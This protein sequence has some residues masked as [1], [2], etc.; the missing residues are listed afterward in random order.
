VADELPLLKLVNVR[1]R[2]TRSVLLPRDWER[3]DALEGYVLT[4]G[5]RDIL[6]RLASSLRGE[7]PTRAWSL[8]GPYGSG[9]SAFALLVSQVLS[10]TGKA[11]ERARSAVKAVDGALWKRLTEGKKSLTHGGLLFPI[12][13]TGSREPLKSALV[14]GLRQGLRRCPGRTPRA[15]TKKLEDFAGRSLFGGTTADLVDLFEDV[16]KHVTRP[17]SGYQGLLLVIDELGKFLEYA[18]SHPEDGDVFALQTLA[19]AAARSEKPFLLLTILH[20]AIDRYTAHVSPARRQEWAKIQGRFEDVAFEEPTEQFLRL[21]A[22]AIE[23]GGSEPVRKSLEQYGRSLASEAW[24]QGCRSGSID[25]REFISLLTACMPLH[26]TAALVLGPLFRRLAQNERSLFAFLASGEPF[27]FQDF[28]RQQ[29]WGRSAGELY[30]LDQLYDYVTT[31]LGS[32]LYSQ[33]RGKYWAEVQSALE[34]L[35]TASQLQVR[36]AKAIGLVQ[37][38]GY[39][40]GTPASKDFLRFALR[41]GAAHDGE[42]SAAVDELERGSVIVYRR[43]AGGYAL[44]EGSDVNIEA[45]LEDARRA[46][47]PARGLTSYLAEFAPPRA[48]VARRHSLQT[49]TLR[50]F[51]VSYADR[52]S[53][54]ALLQQDA[55]GADGQVIYCLP[56]NADDRGVMEA[57]LKDKV[58]GS[59]PAI[60]A[61]LPGE[62]FDLK[63]ACQE[64]S[65]LRWVAQNTPELAG[66]ATARRELRA[67]LAAAEGTLAAQLRRLFLP[68]TRGGQP[69]RWF[70]RGKTVAV[71]SQRGLNE[72]I[73]TVC[74]AVYEFT[75]HWRNELINRR[76][77]S[78]SAA[79]ARRN[80][81]Q[82]MIEHQEEEGLGIQGNP[83]ERSMYESILAACGLHR[84]DEGRW[85]FRPPR[86]KPDAALPAVWKAVE[87]FLRAAEEQQRP[88]TDL[89]SLL[90]AAPYGLKDGVLPVLLTAVL[91]YHDSDVAVYEEGTFIP[92]LSTA[93]LERMLRSPELFAVQCC[94]IVGPRVIVFTKYAAMLSSTT[95]QGGDDEPTLL[96]V[97]RALIKFVRSLPDYVGRTEK[98]GPVA[99]AVLG[100]LKEAR[101]PD[102]LLFTDLPTACGEQP[103]GTRGSARQER[104]E[105]FFGTLRAALAELQQAYPRLQGEIGQI[106]I[107]VFGL[108]GPLAEARRELIHRAKVISEL[109]VEQRLK[110]FL[111]RVL[112]TDSDD[113]MWL[114]SLAALLTGKP[115]RS[116]N[117]EDRARYEASLSLT[118]RTFKH[119]ETLAFEMEQR[120]ASFLDGDEQAL[121]VAVTLPHQP[122]VERVVRIPSRLAG[123]TG[124]VHDGIR[125]VL[126]SVDL[127]A[128]RELS[129]AI[130]AQLVR[131]L[132]A[133]EKSQ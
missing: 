86:R 56:L 41:G 103:F 129:A 28:L 127:L 25:E 9:K 24:S 35:N 54:G 124:E 73:S 99:K 90:R 106:L 4:P 122:E 114:E 89:F 104:V 1:S 48:L 85:G 22:G 6:G 65:C 120:G 116:W 72:F 113:A 91:L 115:T 16:I 2:F 133:N 64:L 109:A 71:A 76:S 110:S 49:G 17:R 83:P 108:T 78:S 12:L 70:H 95:G 79:A 32:V 7:S 82:A 10:D 13:I 92:V 62:L 93:V 111:L 40:A 61:A 38:L 30:R 46:V 42:I 112:E 50:Y 45:R 44:W 63:E 69:C 98:V 94:R 60:I 47:D 8:I 58:L 66:D 5:G 118:A 52:N 121:R 105:T 128:D 21:L 123:K 34:R 77:L 55:G 29:S 74:D 126:E 88:V 84:R 102:Q 43:H 18:A 19:E 57:A 81:I 100:A 27:G 131:E 130:L 11:G 80:L 117:D 132:L 87:G 15:L 39:S 3:D 101:Q 97:V 107:G 67:R 14:T 26:P 51:D 59:R 37:A 125:R 36:V 20:Q 53:L 31:A 119:F 68:A 23:H 33:H 96:K 75:P